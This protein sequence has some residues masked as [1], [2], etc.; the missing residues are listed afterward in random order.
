[1]LKCTNCYKLSKKAKVI[2]D[3]IKGSVTIPEICEKYHVLPDE[4]LEW[5]HEALRALIACFLTTA[6]VLPTIDDHSM[7]KFYEVTAHVSILKNISQ[8]GI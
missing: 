5:K 1:M 2:L 7:Q 4:V 6:K 8:Q 3:L